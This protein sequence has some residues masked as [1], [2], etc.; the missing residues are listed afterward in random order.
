M[1]LV[2]NSNI[3]ALTAQR[4]LGKSNSKL[5]QSLERLSSGL[6]INKASDDAAGI[7]IA[8]KF[9][10]QVRGLNQAIRN[11]NNAIT[12]TQ[13]AEGGIDTVTNILQRLRELA[14]QSSSDDNTASDRANLETESDNLVA[15]LTRVVNTSEYNTMG[16][17]DGSFTGRSFQVG[18]NYGQNISLSIS[19]SRGNAIGNIAELNANV[20]DG[21][22]T[23]TDAGFT[24]G[25]FTVN[26]T[27]IVAT[28]V[29]DDQYS[30]LD[31]SSN[32]I[33]VMSA[34]ADQSVTF[35]INGTTVAVDIASNETGGSVATAITTAIIAA[36]IN[37][38]TARTTDTSGWVIEATNGTNLVLDFA[39]ASGTT[40]AWIAALGMDGALSGMWM[41]A[42]NA[43]GESS[44][45]AKA[46][47]IN[48][49]S[50]TT[51][52]NAS[53]QANSVTTGTVVGGTISSGDI[54][55]NGID[56]GALTIQ[57]SD[58]NG[59]LTTAI[60]AISSST[61][62]TATLASGAITLT[63][64]DGRNIS[65]TADTQADG[66]AMGL[67]TAHTGTTWTYRSTVDM[68]DNEA[69][70]LASSTNLG[71]VYG[72]TGAY[73]TTKTSDVNTPVALDTTKNVASL[74]IST[75]AGAQ[76]AIL[77]VDSALDRINTIRA[78]LG[79]VQNRIGFTVD[80]LEIASENMSAS[81]SRI[82]DA[83]FAAETAIFARNQIMVQAATAILAQ[84]NTMPQMALQLLG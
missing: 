45:I 39:V 77:I 3:S 66:T 22:T 40:T 41:A 31:I 12:L 6:R 2:V 50:T 16:L 73:S 62:V 15:E 24:A 55:I 37:N 59:A 52:V 11:A 80:N 19:D 68:N 58:A 34:T 38:V 43:N 83:D 74:S 65:I 42:T 9:G 71:D 63:A 78:E 69:F 36:D 8:T 13:T 51:G 7:A 5:G 61:G 28:N 53:V 10:S 30:V 84:A 67:G 4:N 20:A 26:G 33:A 44:A 48:S 47:A 32:S 49:I 72:T 35:T 64:A 21:V 82:M 46:S 57:A 56:L 54:Y 76:E 25:E 81:K 79:A 27:N 17:L 18:A 75:T 14:V 60:N 1:S 23:A 70:T 29:T